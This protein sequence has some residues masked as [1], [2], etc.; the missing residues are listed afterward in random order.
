MDLLLSGV[1]PRLRLEGETVGEYAT[2]SILPLARLR[3]PLQDGR[4]VPYMTAGFG[5]IYGEFNDGRHEF[6]V[7]AKGLYPAV[8]VGGGL[9]YFI[10]RG[11]SVTAD[12]WWQY[13]WGHE[14]KVDGR[15][16]RGD[17]SSLQLQLGFRAYLFKTKKKARPRL[18][19][20]PRSSI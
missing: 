9:E 11:F 3:L 15:Q 18:R 16:F 12:T 10:H 20:R 8:A 4:W 6:D 5:A 19:R 1:E 7:S 13:S 2:F 17:F 14:F